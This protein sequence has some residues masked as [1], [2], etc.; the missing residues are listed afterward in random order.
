MSFSLL[1]FPAALRV[2]CFPPICIACR[3]VMESPAEPICPACRS[4]LRPVRE[5]DA[6]YR[7]AVYRLCGDGLIAGTWSLYHFEKGG[8]VQALV[9][10]L[11]YGDGADIGLRLGKELGKQLLGQGLPADIRGIVPV[12]LH[13][14]KERERGYNQSVYLARGISREI[15]APVLAN[16]VLRVR[17]TD[18]QTTLTIEQ[19]RDNVADAFRVRGRGRR[20]LNGG[21]VVLADDVITTG[22][23]VRSCA[24]A[25]RAAGVVAV[26]ACSI[27][28]AE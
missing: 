15:G 4:A 13:R 20:V 7:R 1:S 22:S 26:Y 18:S 28:L 2:F 12:P 5:T 6:I 24:V 17:Y 11:K 10:T 23:T 14:V 21:G 9:H 8:P 25:L 3:A 16:E 27:G 19:R